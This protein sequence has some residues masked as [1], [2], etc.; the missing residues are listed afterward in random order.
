MCVFI[1]FTAHNELHWIWYFKSCN[2]LSNIFCVTGRSRYNNLFNSH[3]LFRPPKWFCMDDANFS[4]LPFNVSVLHLNHFELDALNFHWIM[5]MIC[6][7]LASDFVCIFSP[8]RTLSSLHFKSW[9]YEFSYHKR[10][11]FSPSNNFSVMSLNL[12][13]SFNVTK[14]VFLCCVA[15]SRFQT[16]QNTIINKNTYK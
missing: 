1:N 5:W 13:E 7:S 8:I 3:V 6:Y 15:N 9:F 10:T 11:F 16:F 14:D 12:C 2:F 4:S